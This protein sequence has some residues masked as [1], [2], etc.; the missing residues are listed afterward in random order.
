MLGLIYPDDVIEVFT[1]KINPSLFYQLTD[2]CGYVS[3]AAATYSAT[4]NSTPV[5]P[6]MNAARVRV[7]LP[8]GSVLNILSKPCLEEGEE[9]GLIILRK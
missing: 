1:N 9:V 3:C 5:T 6:K 8:V 4:S 7:K 2:G